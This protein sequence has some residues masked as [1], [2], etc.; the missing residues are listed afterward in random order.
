MQGVYDFFKK[1]ILVLKEGKYIKT[2]V[3]FLVEFLG[4][5]FYGII[6]MVA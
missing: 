4:S 3:R 5:H 1:R 6:V 2:C